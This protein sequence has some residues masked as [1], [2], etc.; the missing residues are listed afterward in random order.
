[1]GTIYIRLLYNGYDPAD[2]PFNTR[3]HNV[4][5]IIPD[6]MRPTTGSW[7]WQ[8]GKTGLYPLALESVSSLRGT[9]ELFFTPYTVHTVPDGRG[10][11]PAPGARQHQVTQANLG[12]K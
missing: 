1:M 9:A 10:R 5:I 8:D 2:Q 11:L 6:V 12:A 7:R 4:S 3:V